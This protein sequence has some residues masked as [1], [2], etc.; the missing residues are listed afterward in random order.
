MRHGSDLPMILV[1]AASGR[2]GSATAMQLLELGYPVRA[3]VRHQD[4]RARR[5]SEA[6][7]EVVEGNLYDMRD[8]RGALTGVERAYYCPPIASNLLHGVA[9]F[10]LAAE[11][12]HLESIT[13]LSQWTPHPTHPSVVTREHWLANN[14][15]KWMPSVS[16]VHVNPGL[17]ADIYLV[18][19]PGAAQFGLFTMPIGEGRNAPPST[20]DIARCVV[21]TLVDPHSHAGQSYRPTGPDLLSGSDMAR[22]G[23]KSQGRVSRYSRSYALKSGGRTGIPSVRDRSAWLLPR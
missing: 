17:F 6:G 9:M 7:A 2:T 23:A 1:T 14:L 4:A 5:L 18:A 10:A 22:E 16:L 21:V 19:T 15:L 3:F 11:E 8:L 13:L 12:A 20:D